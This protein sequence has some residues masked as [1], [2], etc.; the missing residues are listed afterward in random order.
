MRGEGRK[1]PAER[2]QHLTSEQCNC[3][4]DV[5]SRGRVSRVARGRKDPKTRCRFATG[6]AAQNPRDQ[7]FPH[8]LW[9]ETRWILSL[10][11]PLSNNGQAAR[12]GHP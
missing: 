6:T 8:V 9:R 1:G 11:L 4:E 5:S 7:A 3:R 2:P 10:N 12:V